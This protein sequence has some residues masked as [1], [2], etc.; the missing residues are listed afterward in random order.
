VF[1][2][3]FALDIL[4]EHVE[5]F[6]M[7]EFVHTEPAQLQVILERVD[8]A[9]NVARYYVLP[10]EQ[11]LFAHDA[12]IRR[13]SRIESPGRPRLQSFGSGGGAGLTLE[14]WL[15]RK[16]RGSHAVK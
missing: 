3:K 11:A 16:R 10:V 15:E 12:L 13:G 8:P 7:A 4:G 14:A 2:S 6:G 5:R 1:D 9:R